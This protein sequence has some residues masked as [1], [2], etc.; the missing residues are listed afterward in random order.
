MDAS[1]LVYRVRG[2]IGEAERAELVFSGRLVV[3]RGLRAVRALCAL[4]D[5]RLRAAFGGLDPEL[6]QRHLAPEVWLARTAP[7]LRRFGREGEV[8]RLVTRMLVEAG[9]PPSATYRDRVAL[10]AVPAGH[11]YQGGVRGAT[12]VHRDTWGSG[13][14]AQVNW[15]APVYPVTAGRTLLVYPRYWRHPIANTSDAWDFDALLAH[16][17][18][19]RW[20]PTV[21]SPTEPVAAG[22]EFPVLL[23]PGELLCFSAAHL[24]ASAPN[25]TGRTRFSVEARTVSLGD[26]EAGRAAPNVDGCGRAA[27]LEWF[28]SL[29]DGTRLA[30]APEGS[31]V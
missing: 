5:A 12:G 13:V 11:G 6:A 10:R 8:Q 15:W 21:P 3:L 7:V 17:R 23:E 28:R 16:R 19:G 22:S 30:P 27:R 18:C 26:L 9:C 20:Y 14:H 1:T 4:A 31:L 2:P 25:R 29:A 24:H